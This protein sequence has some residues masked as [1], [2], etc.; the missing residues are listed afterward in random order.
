MPRHAM[1]T[2]V[3]DGGS[4]RAEWR[5]KP[6]KFALNGPCRRNRD[7]RTT[8]CRKPLCGHDS[9]L[10]RFGPVLRMAGRRSTAPAHD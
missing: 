4:E 1:R 3:C 8:R 10:I 2:K 7:S 9:P 5:Q 6:G